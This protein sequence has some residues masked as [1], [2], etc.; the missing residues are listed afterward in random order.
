MIFYLH[1]QVIN[2]ILLSAQIPPVLA[3]ALLLYLNN[4]GHAKVRRI[5]RTVDA[6]I[7]DNVAPA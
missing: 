2:I 6:T 1:V 4:L 3:V 7:R 5:S